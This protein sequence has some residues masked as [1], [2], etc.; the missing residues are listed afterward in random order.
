MPINTL[1]VQ[2]CQVGNWL[3]ISNSFIMQLSATTTAIIVINCQQA[4]ALVSGNIIKYATK[5]YVQ[6]N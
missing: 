6:L 4:Q 1:L 2:S 3:I 5:S